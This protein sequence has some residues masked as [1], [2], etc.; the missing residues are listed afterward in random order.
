MA[1]AEK[2]DSLTSEGEGTLLTP[3]KTQ[4]LWHFLNSE[5]D[6]KECTGPL[7][8]YSFMTGFID[9]ISFSSVFVWCG[10]QTGN[11]IQLSLALARLFE[12]GPGGVIDR[13]FHKADQQALCSLICFQ[14]G[15]FVGRIGD[16]IGPH[17]RIWLVFGTFLQSLFT[18]AAA[19]AIWKSGQ[20]GVADDRGD[21]SWTNALSFVCL[22]FMSLSLGLQGHLGK[23]LNTQFGTTIVLTTIWVELFADPAL[24]RPKKVI[25]RDHKLI[26]AGTL[27]IG[28][29]AS[30]AI[31]DK[32]GPAGVLGVGTGI[33]F[34]ICF[35]WLLVP[36]K[37][38]AKSQGAK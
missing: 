17:K 4:S 29:F 35:S 19:L 36:G 24:F 11:F 22:G 8:A 13:T 20:P 31:L 12:V 32:I 15:A 10:F 37:K 7:A 3:T 34:L 16:R 2:R 9:A 1:D 23:R 14:L 28:G 25:S 5:V 18:M 26:A 6:S 21:P 27:F 30:R 38:L 33:R